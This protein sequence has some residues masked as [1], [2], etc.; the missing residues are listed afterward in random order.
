MIKLI[1]RLLLRNVF[2]FNSSIR[3]RD[4]N[5]PAFTWDFSGFKW[6]QDEISRERE[7]FRRLNF[8]NLDPSEL[9][10]I[11]VGLCECAKV[12]YTPQRAEAYDDFLQHVKDSI[13][14]ICNNPS[15]IVQGFINFIS[16]IC[17]SE[18][19]KA[20]LNRFYETNR[21]SKFESGS[22]PEEDGAIALERQIIDLCKNAKKPSKISDFQKS[23]GTRDLFEEFSLQQPSANERI[24]ECYI[25]EKVYN[26]HDTSEV[27]NTHE[28]QKRTEKKGFFHSMFGFL[29]E[30]DNSK[31]A[32]LNWFLEEKAEDLLDYLSTMKPVQEFENPYN[33]PEECTFSVSIDIVPALQARGWPK[34]A[35]E[36]INRK[37]H[38][39]SHETIHTIVQ[40]GFHLVV[41]SPK[42]GG[43]SNTMFR[44]SF[45][46]AEYLLSQQLHDDQRKCYRALKKYYSACL[47][48]KPKSLATYHLKTLF[49]QT[50]EETRADMWTEENMTTCMMTLLANL[51]SSL[52]EKYLRHFFIKDCNL[53]D[54]KNIDN[55]HLL[56]SLAV[57]VEQFMG[58][59]MDF[60][61]KMFPTRRREGDLKYEMAIS[62]QEDQEGCIKDTLTSNPEGYG[63]LTAE[64]ENEESLS[65]S[66]EQRPHRMAGTAKDFAGLQGT[67]D[68][69][70]TG[71]LRSA[72]FH[73]LKDIYI[74]TCLE[75]LTIATED[76]TREQLDPLQRSLVEDIRELISKY[77]YCPE[78]LM[79][80]FESLWGAVYTRMAVHNEFFTKQ[81]MLAALKD[82]IKV[83]KLAIR[84]DGLLGSPRDYS[85]LLPVDTFV[86]LY[87]RTKRILRSMEPKQPT[88]KMEDIPLD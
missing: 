48:T 79:D 71:M 64:I 57:K 19:A 72:R 80:K 45:S 35:R 50:C 22:K 33:N 14:Y 13:P 63:N 61:P 43:C 24:T 20:I 28:E 7:Y 29:S 60:Y 84:R 25:R 73:D 59:P 40:E 44:L 2:Q 58:N 85:L 12:D 15:G 26:Y 54:P 82:N 62:N 3:E 76:C 75:L 78:K 67:R 34:V 23:V 69:V 46:H 47:R 41:K 11:M 77:D 9:E 55:P 83:I 88:P 68:P 1:S 56:D 18:K 8:Q 81:S 53:F 38:W 16:E 10:Y 65:A 30:Q 39:P 52:S 5:S 6:T 66:Q 17:F 42:G 49:L 36:W 86:S 31:Q 87:R 70:E 74:Q 4:A 37:R 32:L 27:E 21:E 51:H